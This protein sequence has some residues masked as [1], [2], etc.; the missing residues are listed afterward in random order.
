ML[1]TSCSQNWSSADFLVDLCFYRTNSHFGYRIPRQMWIPKQFHFPQPSPE[2][3]TAVPTYRFLR[4]TTPAWMVCCSKSMSNNDAVQ[5]DHNFQND[6]QTIKCSLCKSSTPT[7][8]KQTA[9]QCREDDNEN[10]HDSDDMYESIVLDMSNISSYSS[11]GTVWP[12]TMVQAH[13][14]HCANR[15]VVRLFARSN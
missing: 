10:Q 1:E 13:G 2:P 9:N 7:K 4:S 6:I 15:L 8:S 3:N 14:D 5:Y 12:N 11:D